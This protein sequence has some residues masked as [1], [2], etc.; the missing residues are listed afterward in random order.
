MG[1]VRYRIRG[2]KNPSTIECRFYHGKNIEAFAKTELLIDPKNWDAKNERVKNLISILDRSEIN[3]KLSLLKDTIFDKFNLAY[4]NGEVINSPW[5]KDV[6]KDFF[7]RPDDSDKD[8]LNKL[9]YYVD[10]SRNWLAT[11]SYTWKTDEGTTMDD[12]LR[13]HYGRF[14]DILEKY[15]K[16][17][18]IG[19][20]RLVKANQDTIQ[21]FANYMTDDEGYQRTTTLRHINRFKFF[22]RRAE[23]ENIKI[24]KTVFDRIFVSKQRKV[25]DPFF[26]IDE[27]KTLFELSLDDY[28]LDNARDNLI[29]ACWTGLR[30]SDFLEKLNKS[31][32][33][34]GFIDLTT[35]KTSKEVVIPVH[36]MV[37]F[38]LDKRNGELPHKMDRKVFNSKIKKVCEIAGFTDLVLGKKVC[39]IKK[40]KV[41]GM[42]KKCD[43]VSSH[44]GRRTFATNHYGKLPDEVIMS[45][46]GWQ[47]KDTMIRYLKKSD[48]SKA[49]V[50]KK[51]WDEQKIYN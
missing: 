35:T 44:I 25:L 22:F 2:N 4:S 37:Q 21:D 11:K 12:D 36:D 50:M 24:N 1:R 10:F 41:I 40:R 16:D 23:S 20:I 47:K 51:Y 49:K 43:L 14:L 48:M 3:K 38:I 5:L 8:A 28:F 13:Y 17:K 19:K 34:D 27:L 42:Y 6:I 30:V 9:T 46:C 15:Q 18:K 33:K 29:I 39:E 45:I 32:F 26:D 31:N 7:N